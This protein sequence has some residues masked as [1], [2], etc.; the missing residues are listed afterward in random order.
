MAHIFDPEERHKLDSPERRAEMPPEET[1][2]KAGIK[3]GD[4]FLDIGCGTG[5]FSLPAAR[6]I[7]PKGVVYALDVSGVMLAELR[8]KAAS[9]G[10][11]NIQTLQ[12]A[13]AKLALPE[14]GV[15]MAL[16]SDVLHE[17]DD[18]KAFFAAISAAL[19]PGARLAV[20]EWEKKE[21]PKGPPLKERLSEDEMQVL[22]KK[23]GFTEPASAGLGS[24]HILYTCERTAA[25]ERSPRGRSS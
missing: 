17:V 22:L 3:P 12:T 10:V 16:I 18:K 4:I 2:V 24:A 14:A 25:A 6:M 19:K 21:T 20:I 23:A 1:L 13:R 11:F 5:Y 8:S 9:Q 7:G 15:T